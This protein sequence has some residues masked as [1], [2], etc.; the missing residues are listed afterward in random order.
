MRIRRVRQREPLAR[1][2]GR[3]Q[4]RGGRGGLAEADGL[5]VRPDELHRV[6]DRRQRGE[7]ATGR[8]DVDGDVAVGVHRLERSSWA[9]TSLADASSICTPRK[10]MRSSNSLV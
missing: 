10:M 7:R 5:D 3:E 2:A 1:R 8:V 9:M 6:V 4:H